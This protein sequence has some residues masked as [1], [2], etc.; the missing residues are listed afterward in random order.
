MLLSRHQNAGQNWDIKIANNSLENVSQF[1]YLGTTVRNQN[2]IQE[3]ITKRVNFGNA[4]I[5]F[6]TFC[7]LVCCQKT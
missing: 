4:T 2:L 6:R 3:D 5:R 1:K 7:L